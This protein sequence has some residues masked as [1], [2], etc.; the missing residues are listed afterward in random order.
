ML[1]NNLRYEEA[2]FDDFDVT[3]FDF[4]FG[5]DLILK[6]KRE[7]KIPI[8]MGSFSILQPFVLMYSKCGRIFLIIKGRV[9][10]IKCTA[11]LTYTQLSTL[12]RINNIPDPNPDQ[13]IYY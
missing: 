9:Q 7:K 8:K 3:G 10:N 5:I 4:P 2:Q 13:L 1:N 12:Y 11:I 6:A